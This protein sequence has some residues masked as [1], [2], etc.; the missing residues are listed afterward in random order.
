MEEN[1]SRPVAEKQMRKVVLK[2]RTILYTHRTDPQVSNCTTT[3]ESLQF[4]GLTSCS[5]ILRAVSR[6]SALL[7]RPV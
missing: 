1:N 3:L 6:L 4:R 5:T 2:P 7:L